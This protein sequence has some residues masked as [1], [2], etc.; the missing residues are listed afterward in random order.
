[1]SDACSLFPLFQDPWPSCL[2]PFHY[3]SSGLFFRIMIKSG[4]SQQWQT[5]SCESSCQGT[6]NERLKTRSVCF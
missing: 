4:V 1:M 5:D 3:P 6:G 2:L